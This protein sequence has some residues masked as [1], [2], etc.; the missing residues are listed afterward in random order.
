[1]GNIQWYP[2]HMKKAL[3]EITEN[4]KLIDVVIEILDARIP[5]ASKNPDIDNFARDKSR[6]IILSKE[7]MAEAKKTKEWISYFNDKGFHCISVDAR[8]RNSV[9]RVSNIINEAAKAKRERDRKRG[10]LKRPVR[11]LICGIPNSGKSTFINSYIGKKSTKTGDKPGVT[12][13]KQWIRLGN[14][15]E[16]LDT[17]GILWPKFEDETTGEYLAFC[18][19]IRGEI[20]EKEELSVKLLTFLNYNRPDILME[21]YNIEAEDPANQLFSIAKTRNFLIAGGK[22]DIKRAAEYVLEEFRSGK[23]GNIT[24]E[25]VEHER[26]STE[27]K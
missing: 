3:R 2:G 11:C 9:K 12:K 26:K 8:N 27:N 10:I 22:P 18:G 5:N 7:D 1:M 17:P 23:L 24:I 4:I 25:S 6:V 15:I 16:L 21:K 14:D 13:G 20:L 19:S